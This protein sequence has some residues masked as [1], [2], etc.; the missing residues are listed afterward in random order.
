MALLHRLSHTGWERMTAW[1]YGL[2]LVALFLVS[3]VFHVITW[4]KSHMRSAL[5]GCF[6]FGGQLPVAA[7]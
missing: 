3:T 2:G 6:Y 5:I 4:K 1:V 7:G